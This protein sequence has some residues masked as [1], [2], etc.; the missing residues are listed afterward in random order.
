M[1]LKYYIKGHSHTPEDAVTIKTPAYGDL[2][3]FDGD[4]LAE[5]CA[6]YAWDHNDG[7]EWLRDGETLS[8]ILGG[9]EIGDYEITVE[10]EPVFSARKK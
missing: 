6:S 7:W 5:M 4:E 9:Q 3:L 2:T 8:L 1:E 10:T